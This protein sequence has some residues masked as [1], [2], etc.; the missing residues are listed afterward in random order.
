[1]CMYVEM[2]VCVHVIGVCARTHVCVCACVCVCVY[3]FMVYNVPVIELLVL[4]C[5]TAFVTIMFFAKLTVSKARFAFSNG[6]YL[7]QSS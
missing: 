7:L 1:M 2:C 4:V 5:C 6:R 3:V